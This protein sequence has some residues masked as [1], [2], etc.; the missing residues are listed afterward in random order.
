MLILLANPSRDHVFHLTFPKEWKFNDISHLFSP[1]G[2]YIYIYIY[3]YSNPLYLIIIFIYTNT[4]L[5][6]LQSFILQEVCMCH[7]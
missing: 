1:F 3:M 4:I 5:I 2:K 6:E 7:G